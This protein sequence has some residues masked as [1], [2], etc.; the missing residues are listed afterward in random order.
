[1][2][3]VSQMNR[4]PLPGRRC[5]PNGITSPNARNGSGIWIVIVLSSKSVQ[6]DRCGLSPR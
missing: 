1:M 2:P 5:A 3:S 4:I 6:A